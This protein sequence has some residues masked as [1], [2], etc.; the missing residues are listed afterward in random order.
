M[1]ESKYQK[2]LIDKLERLYPGCVILKTEP[3][4]LQGIP[5]LVIFYGAHWAMLEVKAKAT[6]P[7]QVNQPY[8]V[9]LLNGMSFASFINPSNE[10]EVLGELEKA[11]RP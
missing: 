4:Y 10:E 5:D 11:L 3:S 9:D 7:I 6:S 8:Y 1:S 2:R